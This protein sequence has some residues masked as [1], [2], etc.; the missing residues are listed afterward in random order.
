MHQLLNQLQ[1]S[2]AKYQTKKQRQEAP[3][4]TNHSCQKLQQK[5]LSQR[6]RYDVHLIYNHQSFVLRETQKNQ[7]QS[8]LKCTQQR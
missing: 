7:L 2:F 8:F 3:L 1:S 6:Y 4:T 5:V